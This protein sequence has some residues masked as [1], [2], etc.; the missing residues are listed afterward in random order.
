LTNEKEE[1]IDISAQSLSSPTSVS[2]EDIIG[3][4]RTNVT[5]EERRGAERLNEQDVL[6]N[7]HVLLDPKEKF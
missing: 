1:K 7:P 4:S 6:T 2:V 5:L 3:E